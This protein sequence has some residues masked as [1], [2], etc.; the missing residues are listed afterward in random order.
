MHTNINKLQDMMVQD[1]Q[2]SLEDPRALNQDLPQALDNILLKENFL[3]KETLSS[4]LVQLVEM[5]ASEL[6]I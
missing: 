1:R 5:E 4:L 3:P 6:G 2:W